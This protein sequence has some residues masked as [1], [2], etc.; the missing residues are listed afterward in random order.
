[1]VNATEMAKF[2]GKTPKDWLRTD[3]SKEFINTLSAVRQICQT[4]LVSVRQGGDPKMQGTWMHEDAALEFARWLSPA[5]AIWCNDRIK[6]LLI[7]KSQPAQQAS[8]E[9]SSEL[10]ANVIDTIKT[11]NSELKESQETIRRQERTLDEK[12]R[13]IAD[14]ERMA[15]MLDP[16]HLSFCASADFQFVM[17]CLARMMRLELLK[18]E[19][20]DRIDQRISEIEKKLN[21]LERAVKFEKRI[22]KEGGAA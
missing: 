21:I 2:F 17:D 19:R 11:L 14:L 6:E 5:F 7:G 1:M 15:N 22:Y 12:S 16:K 4:E 18:A 3:A 13:V 20:V 8:G 10:E 9:I